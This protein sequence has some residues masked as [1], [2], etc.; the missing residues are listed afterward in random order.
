MQAQESP[1]DMSHEP[2]LSKYLNTLEQPYEVMRLEKHP[3]VNRF[4]RGDYFEKSY[5]KVQGTYMYEILK[6]KVQIDSI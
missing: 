1:I 3:T 4:P 6:I 5:L 2:F